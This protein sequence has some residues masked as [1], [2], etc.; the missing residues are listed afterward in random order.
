MRV[1]GSVWSYEPR[2]ASQIGILN[3]RLQRPVYCI[4]PE[5]VQPIESSLLNGPV[6]CVRRA[7]SA[8]SD[9]RSRLGSIRGIG[10]EIPSKV[11]RAIVN[12]KGFF[13]G[14]SPFETC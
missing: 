10:K 9:N 5:R 3:V 7:G 14:R 2:G 12:R 11:I 8:I 6:V 13:L 4:L 1:L